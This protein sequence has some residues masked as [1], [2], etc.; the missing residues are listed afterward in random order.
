MIL[1]KKHFKKC[2]YSNTRLIAAHDLRHWIH[3]NHQVKVINIWG[4]IGRAVKGQGQS[5]RNVLLKWRETLQAPA[6][7]LGSFGY[8]LPIIQLWSISPLPLCMPLINR[9]RCWIFNLLF[10]EFPLASRFLPKY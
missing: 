10:T 4:R 3:K 2:L 9:L 6:S 5:H 8:L 1:A 7:N